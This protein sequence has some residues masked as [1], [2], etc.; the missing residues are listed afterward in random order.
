MDVCFCQRIKRI[1]QSKCMNWTLQHFHEVMTSA[2]QSVATL[3]RIPIS[4]AIG[5]KCFS[6]LTSTIYWKKTTTNLEFSLYRQ[7]H[8]LIEVFYVQGLLL[9]LLCFQ[10]CSTFVKSCITRSKSLPS[11]TINFMDF[12]SHHTLMP[13]NFW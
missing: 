13:V 2:Y 7:T 4:Q 5:T 11:Q 10:A 1:S 6:S 3:M 9:T 12:W 8:K